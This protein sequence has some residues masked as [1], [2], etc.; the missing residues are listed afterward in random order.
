MSQKQ[1]LDSGPF[2]RVRL[3]EGEDPG[4]LHPGDA[5][6]WISI[7]VELLNFKDSL[8]ERS[9]TEMRRL[10]APARAE[11]GAGDVRALLDQRQRWQSRLDFWY[12]RYWDLH[13]LEL[14]DETHAVM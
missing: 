8:I 7:Y 14:D 3:L 1:L 6:H 2:T 4:T 9:A 5:R 12:E 13:G 10:S 11:L